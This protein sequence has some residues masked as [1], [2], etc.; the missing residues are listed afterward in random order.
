MSTVLTALLLK[1]M[2]I[3]TQKKKKNV[4][5]AQDAKLRLNPLRSTKPAARMITIFVK[6]PSKNM[7]VK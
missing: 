7:Y 6:I 5:N 2:V 1:H 3:Q 4:L